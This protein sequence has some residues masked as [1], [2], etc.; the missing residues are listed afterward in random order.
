MKKKYSNIE[1]EKKLLS[2]IPGGTHTYSKGKDQFP[3]NAPKV[4]KKG[5]GAYIYDSEGKKFLSWSMGLYTVILGHAYKPVINRVI[6]E[7]YNGVNFQRPSIL[8]LEFAEL[9]KKI[10]PCAEM[11]KFAKNGS[12]TTTA[13]IKLSRAYNKK[14]KIAVCA[15]N[16]FFSYDDWF[17]GSTPSNRGIP[18]KFMDQVFKFNYNDIK[19]VEKILKKNGHEI[20]ALIMEP[21]KF[22]EPKNNFLKKVKSLCKKYKVVF[23]LD[24]MITG[25]R[26]PLGGAQKYY[27]VKPDLSTFGKSLA[28][29]F[30]MSFLTGKKEIM[31]LGGIQQGQMKTFLVS[32]THGAE[33]HSIA[34]AIQT[35]KELK[36]HN[37]SNY[38]WKVGK[39]LK[40]QI[41]KVIK[42][43][44]LEKYVSISGHPYLPIMYFKN[45]K[46]QDSFE[47]K[48]L[49]MQELIKSKILFQ[50]FFATSYMHKKK[51]IDI[52][53]KAIDDALKVYSKALNTGYKRYLNGEPIKPVFRAIN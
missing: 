19:G 42:K 45:E 35:I 53:L 8:E 16:P 15:Q 47:Y 33:T 18:K 46:F 14:Y 17:I 20:T 51:E 25:F 39:N 30:S 40:S 36:K 29:G 32:S 50:G 21:L 2:L 13:A 52:T 3:S 48:T 1:A 38:L 34:A 49:F 27:G 6:K 5:E 31:Q 43:N 28:N 9:V 44:K 7:L 4:I 10:I 12:T 41:T 23:I 24:E 37:V 26:F 22:E 11:V